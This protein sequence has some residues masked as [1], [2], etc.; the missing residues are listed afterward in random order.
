MKATLFCM[1]I[2]AFYAQAAKKKYGKSG[3]LFRRSVEV[4]MGSLS[5]YEVDEPTSVLQRSDSWKNMSPED[6]KKKQQLN[7]TTPYWECVRR[8]V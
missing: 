8:Q 5:E 3:A 4:D 7:F 1:V 2:L 6:R